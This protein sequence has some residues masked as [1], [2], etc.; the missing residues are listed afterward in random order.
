MRLSNQ[1]NSMIQN[2]K[3]ISSQLAL[4]G[5]KFDELKK[6]VGI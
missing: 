3:D 1:I 5:T 2:S 4:L 6:N